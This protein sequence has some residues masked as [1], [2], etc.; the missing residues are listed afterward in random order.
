V[1]EVDGDAGL[2]RL[3]VAGHSGRLCG[4]VCDV[5]ARLAEGGLCQGHHLV[6]GEGRGDVVAHGDGGGER[7]RRAG[8]DCLG[9]G[10]G[11]M[12][13]GMLAGAGRARAGPG[14]GR[15]EGEERA[16]TT[17]RDSRAPPHDRGSPCCRREALGCLG[18]AGR[19]AP[20]RGRRIDSRTAAPEQRCDVR[21]SS[22][23]PYVQAASCKLPPPRADVSRPPSS[24]M[25]T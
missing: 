22:A 3:Q 9:V 16:R 1:A 18:P 2:L 6:V 15:G 13:G 17:C 7:W 4:A 24:A 10:G 14:R 11:S 25:A 8:E 19:N 20:R 23:R 12:L 5:V 21:E